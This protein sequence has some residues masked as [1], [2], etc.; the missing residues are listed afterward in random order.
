MAECG[1][2][3][4]Q[5]DPADAQRRYDAAFGD[6]FDYAEQY[7]GSVCGDCAIDQTQ[8][9]INVG[10]AIDMVNGEEAYDDDFVQKHL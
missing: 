4:T 7:G 3:E 8:S 9:E 10:R 1:E 2:C 5:F 6:G